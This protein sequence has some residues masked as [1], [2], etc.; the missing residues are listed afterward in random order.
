MIG[1][2]SRAP[3]SVSGRR[4]PSLC[5]TPRAH[6][7]QRIEHASHRPRAQR[8]I[9]VECRRDRA[10]GDRAHHQAAAGAGIAEIKRRCRLRE[11]RD[12]DA[13]HRPGDIAGPFDLRAQ[14]PHRLGGVEYVLALEQAGDPCFPDRQR[15]KNQRAVRNRLVAGH[16]DAPGQG[17]R[18]R[19]SSG[20]GWPDRVKIV[21]RC[22]RRLVSRGR[23]A[24]RL[25][26]GICK[27][28]LTAARQLAK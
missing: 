2:G 19:G 12:A 28:L 13:V 5:A 1:N 10:S 27:A 6:Q 21:P 22:D 11:A 4:P 15:A 20:V 17:C 16:A 14:R 26:A 18:L 23:G 3:C 24:S 7:F 8:G 25:R 9:A